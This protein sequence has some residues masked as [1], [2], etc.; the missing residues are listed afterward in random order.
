MLN[1]NIYVSVLHSLTAL[2]F[3]L[4]CAPSASLITAA[5]KYVRTKRVNISYVT[6]GDATIGVIAPGTREHSFKVL[7]RSIPFCTS[8]ICLGALNSD[9]AILKTRHLRMA[10]HVGVV[11]SNGYPRWC[12]IKWTTVKP[13]PS[14]L[15]VQQL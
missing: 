1:V 11:S 2:I 4:T 3:V 10:I 15:P 6:G 14:S 12:G 13:K 5:L 8:G 7:T 9:S